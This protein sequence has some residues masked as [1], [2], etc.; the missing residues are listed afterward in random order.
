MARMMRVLLAIVLSSAL[1]ASGQDATANL[2]FPPFDR[3]YNRG[4]EMLLG[5][6]A[7]VENRKLTIVAARR[8]GLGCSPRAVR[9]PNRSRSR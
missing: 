4:F 9:M 3:D 7:A 1:A 8:Q 6:P 5:R 2:P